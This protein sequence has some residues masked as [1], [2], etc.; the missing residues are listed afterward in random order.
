MPFGV[1]ASPPFGI[2][3]EVQRCISG[4]GRVNIKNRSAERMFYHTIKIK[5]SVLE[6][7]PQFVMF[8]W[9]HVLLQ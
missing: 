1:P 3:G 7:L 5:F 2:V 8:L 4:D 6:L 9:R